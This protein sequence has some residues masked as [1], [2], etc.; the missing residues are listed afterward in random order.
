MQLLARNQ[1][2]S[3][4]GN[5]AQ[6]QSARKG[7]DQ[8]QSA[9]KIGRVEGAAQSRPRGS[10]PDFAARGCPG[11]AARAGPAA[12]QRAVRAF[13][14]DGHDVPAVVA[15]N[16]MFDERNL[17]AGGRNTHVREPSRTLVQ[18][19]AAWIF[20]SLG[21]RSVT[22]DGHSRTVRLERQRRATVHG[23]PHQAPQPRGSARHEQRQFAGPRY[24]RQ[25]GT[26][27]T[28]RP[29]FRADGVRQIQ[30][31]LTGRFLRFVDHALAIRSEARTGDRRAPK[32][33]LVKGGLWSGLWTD[34]EQ[35]AGEGH[36]G[37]SGG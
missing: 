10:E 12:R 17:V 1:D 23:H 3:G 24:R 32:G 11:Q 21:P 9:R 4:S 5:V 31:A 28:E 25:H 27:E 34:Y 36:Q 22:N 37:D 35:Q 19:L 29:R 6:R 15:H 33:N 26:R 7:C 30:F 16:G 13:S 18:D 20:N 14:V 8:T 2:A